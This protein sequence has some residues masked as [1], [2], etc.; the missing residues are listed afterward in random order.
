MRGVYL[1]PG[2]WF[3]VWSGAEHVGGGTIEVA[4]PIGRPPVFSRGA[5]RADLRTIEYRPDF[6]LSV[7]GRR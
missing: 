5:D 7:P 4:A 2:T 1:P 6:C 3:D